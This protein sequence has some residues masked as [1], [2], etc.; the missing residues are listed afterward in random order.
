MST[1]ELDHIGRLRLALGG[2]RFQAATETALQHPLLTALG[3]VVIYLLLRTTYD[4]FFSPLRDIPGP[5]VA[6]F[7]G[8]WMRLHNFY[9]RRCHKIHEAHARYG[10]C[11]HP[12]RRLVS[13]LVMAMLTVIRA[14]C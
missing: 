4:A 9:G 14:G 1:V 5:F 3:V 6:R 7:S 11:H 8:F 2:Q 12:F 13:F 10:A